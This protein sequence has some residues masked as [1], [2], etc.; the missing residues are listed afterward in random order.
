MKVV[1]PPADHL[2]SEG[3]PLE[4][5]GSS[6]KYWRSPGIRWGMWSFSGAVGVRTLSL[7]GMFFFEEASVDSTF[8]AVMAK[9]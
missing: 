4:V 2:V 6:G 8:P 7:A 3:Q 9:S 5:W 1:S